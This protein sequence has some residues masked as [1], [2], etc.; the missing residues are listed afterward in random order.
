MSDEQQLR[1]TC[2]SEAIRAHGHASTTPK[3]I[4]EAAKRYLD[5]IKGADTPKA[6]AT[7]A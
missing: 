5:F 7:K 4:V 2:I 6:E 3:E 1:A